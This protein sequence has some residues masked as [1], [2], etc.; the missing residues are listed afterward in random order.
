MS[1]PNPTRPADTG[2]EGLPHTTDE[3]GPQPFD[4]HDWKSVRAQF[5]LSPDLAHLSNFYLASNP[6]PVRDAITKYRKAFDEDPHSFLDDNMFGR[7]EDMLWRTV[8]AE[9][10]EYVGGRADEIALT[11]ST[12][13]G[14]A[15]T[16]NGLRLKPGQEILTTTHEFYPHHEA[17]RLATER[18]GATMRAISLYESSPDFSV[19]EAVARIRAAIRPH[20]RVFGVA[21]VHSNTG[22]RLPISRVADV[23]ADLN[24]DRDE[25]DRVL[26]VVDGV[27]GFG[28]ADEDVAS[29]GCDF[30]SAGTHKWILGPRGTGI[31][32]AKP[33]NW[34][35]LQPTIPSL[36]SKE[37]SAAWRQDRRPA[38]PT[39]ASWI[40]PGG[41]AAY[42]HQWA[43]AEAFRFVRRIGRKRIQDRIA[44]LNGQIKE[45]LAGMDHVTLHTP[46]DPEVSAGIVTFD[47]EGYAPRDVAKILRENRVIAN[48]T[49]Y[50]VPHVRLS[51]GIVNFPEEV[52]LALRVIRSLKGAGA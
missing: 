46:L 50:G 33:E 43:T 1:L 31:M 19:D 40:S 6:T 21:W 22:V 34:A 3:A 26:L 42:E 11:T 13:M 17:I 15:L 30:F 49:P 23:I 45:G 14:L 25:E 20:T 38:G 51:A 24:R 52:D 2:V 4:P 32:W 37:T 39:E 29:M 47:V 27:H 48:A 41:F 5:L 8:C 10:A 28:V 35:L 12:T 44:E 36:M 7:E 16:Y 9:A 18:W